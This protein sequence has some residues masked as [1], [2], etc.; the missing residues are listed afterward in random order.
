L[1][2]SKIVLQYRINKY[3]IYQDTVVCPESSTI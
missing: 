3:H 2:F 1:G